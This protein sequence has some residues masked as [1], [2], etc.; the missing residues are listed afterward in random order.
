MKRIFASMLIVLLLV[1]AYSFLKP[2]LEPTEKP[3]PVPTDITS[4]A[5]IEE[6]V[7]DADEVG[8]RVQE[9]S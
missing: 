5:L 8:K 7:I 4:A 9:E 6:S 1:S 3:E 2:G